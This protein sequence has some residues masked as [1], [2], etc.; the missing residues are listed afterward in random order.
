MIIA[1]RLQN[2]IILEK[3]GVIQVVKLYFAARL[4]NIIILEKDGVVQVVKLYIAARMK[5]ITIL[6][7]TRSEKGSF[8]SISF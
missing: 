4:K 6:E 8:Y 5:N 3:D 2:V 7:N 1:A